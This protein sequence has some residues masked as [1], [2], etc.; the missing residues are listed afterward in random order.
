MGYGNGRTSHWESNARDG[1]DSY[2]TVNDSGEFS[3]DE[4]DSHRRFGR[5]TF[6]ERFPSD[7]Q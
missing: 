6:L 5:R 1:G 2:E 3:D 4:G 7:C